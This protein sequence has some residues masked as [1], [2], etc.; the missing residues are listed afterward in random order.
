[1]DIYSN[2]SIIIVL[3]V[4]INY[5]NFRFIK[6]Q[7]TIAIMTTSLIISILSLFLDRI[8]FHSIHRDVTQFVANLNF[9]DLLMN[10][11]LGCLLFAGSLTIDISQLKKQKWD[12]AILAT[13]SVLAS[14]FI[15][16]IFT[17]YLLPVF[18]IKLSF[19][20]CLLFGALISPTDPIAVLSIFKKSHAPKKLSL[21]IAAESL[22]NDGLAVVLFMTISHFAF[23]PNAH[24]SAEAITFLFLQKSLGG[25]LFGLILSF[26]AYFL[27]KPIDDHKIEIL[28]TLA[29]VTGGYTLAQMISVSGPLAM[30][31]VGIFIASRKR[32][33]VISK[34]SREHIETFWGLIDE[35]LNAI[36]FLLIG[37]EILVI[38]V[39]FLQMF[40]SLTLIPLLL[41][42]RYITVAFPMIFLK[43]KRNYPPYSIRI[44]TWG[45]L[46]GGVAVALALS[47]PF[48]NARDI[49]LPMTYIIVLFSILCQGTTIKYLVRKAKFSHVKQ[50]ETKELISPEHAEAMLDKLSHKPVDILE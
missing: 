9:R 48:G 8:G 50:K 39:S 19:I 25:L 36:L 24:P 7:P 35:L 1:M 38:P 6:M 11:M 21:A 13:I 30:V 18:H 29:L 42:A 45:G 49:I 26:A 34:N 44:M 14:A 32:E 10:L 23:V 2:I 37:F 27:M 41:L 5:I 31:T 33:I 17:Y 40:A 4:F 12:I 16:G 15:I 43:L 3:A 20:S 22:F 47:L 28:L 46:R